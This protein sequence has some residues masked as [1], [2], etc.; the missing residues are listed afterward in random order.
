[1][2]KESQ[3]E[4]Q[5][6]NML[7]FVV[8]VSNLLIKLKEDLKMDIFNILKY[9]QIMEEIQ[10][11]VLLMLKN[12]AIISYFQLKKINILVQFLGKIMVKESIE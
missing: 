3:I 6:T 4:F 7:Y 5:I 9:K 12:N 2:T 1:M 8:K 10:V 11:F